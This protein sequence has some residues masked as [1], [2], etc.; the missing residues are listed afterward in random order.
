[1]AKNVNL[2]LYPEVQEGHDVAEVKEKLCETLSV[3]ADTVDSWYNTDQPTAILKEVDEPTAEKYV[4]A[5]Q[6]CGAQCNLQPI[7]QDK[8]A[9]SLEQMTKADLK[10]LFICPSCEYEEETELDVKP[11]QCPKCGLVIA[12][13]EEKMKEEAEKEKIRRR[14]MRDQRL[15]GDRAED[16]EA[17]RKEL[18]R[19][20]Q[21]EREIMKELG[22]KPPSRFW[23]FYERHPISLSFFATVMIIAVTGV[24]FRYIDL[25]IDQIALEEK[26]L[27]PPSEEIKGIAPAVAAAVNLQQNGNQE[28]MTEIADA[29][30]IMRGELG[31][32]RQEMI[33][34]ASQMMK[35]VESE[36]FIA[37]A[38]QMALPKPNTVATEND[39]AVPVNL[40]T[41]GGVQ[42]LSGVSSFE[43]RDLAEMAPPLLEHGH[44]NVL[45]VLT[46]KRAIKDVLD[47]EGP[48]IIVEAIDEMDGSAIV[49]LMKGVSR[50]QEWDQYLLSHVKRYLLNGDMEAAE[51]V[52]ERIKNPVVR[53]DALSE[54]MKEQLI[55]DD[56]AALKALYSRLRLDLDKLEDA[57]TQARAVLKLGNDL[58][59]SGSST[60]PGASMEIV[61]ALVSG[62]D[63]L[64]EQAS[65]TSRLAVAYME[66]NDP[67]QA[68]ILLGNAMRSAGRIRDLPDRLSAFTRIARRYYDVRN[69]TLATEILAE[70]SVIAAT[71]LPQAERSVAFGEIALA[72]AYIGDF[73]GARQSVAN[74]SEGKASAQL[75]SKIAESLIGEGRYYEALSWMD[76]MTDDVEYGRLELRLASA[77]FYEGRDQEARNRI[78]QS[79]NR[80]RRVTE[81]AERGLLVSQYA[82]F[83]ARLGD[84]SRAEELF[85]EAAAVSRQLSGRKGQVN[86]AI[87]ALDHARVFHLEKSKLIVIEELTDT[88]VKDPIDA[89][90][91]ATERIVKNL[92]PE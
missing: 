40:S 72:Q 76:A 16:L 43:T 21:L 39:P 11:D 38:G 14:L 78:D 22:M 58:A 74:A 52:T 83:Y 51:A 4:K 8:S 66:L 34:A 79:V 55:N 53:I 27:A 42:G 82:R 90:I 77:L 33:Q 10:G 36:K 24:V 3:D 63:D 69:A 56:V 64:K 80:V 5:I 61:S 84:E 46:Q 60:E 68:K 88:V 28:V 30:Q 13:W 1:M 48:D 18:E 15:K 25:Y 91:L 9:W 6:G 29:S 17:K 85:N 37:A 65:L 92:L 75:E 62:S 2:V 89:E 7:G 81:H 32:Q 71:E 67:R 47:P 59:A 70:A 87:I 20:R 49:T 31:Q 19:L 12:K 41:I 73:A 44:E 57:D 26:V 35:G 86:L 45:A 54:L 23:L 50:D